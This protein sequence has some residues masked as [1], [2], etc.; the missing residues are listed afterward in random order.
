MGLL[1]INSGRALFEEQKK[2]EKT[3][4]F[5]GKP[6][7]FLSDQFHTPSLKTERPC[8]LQTSWYIMLLCV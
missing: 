6:I 1:I 4:S 7:I 5:T 3:I 2:K 8:I